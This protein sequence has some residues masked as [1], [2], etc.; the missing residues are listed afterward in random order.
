M[1]SSKTNKPIKSTTSIDTNNTGKTDNPDM[2]GEGNYT[3]ARNYRSKTE[4]FVKDGK[5]QPAA[6]A[7]KPE[8]EQQA[9]E[10]REAERAGKE[11]ARR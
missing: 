6:D 3:A 2:Q 11:P 1:T 8:S 5:V 9:R 7:A 4:A 10:M